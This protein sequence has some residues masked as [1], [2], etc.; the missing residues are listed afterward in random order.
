MRF[1]A[2]KSQELQVSLMLHKMRDLLVRQRAIPINALRAHLGDYG[3]VKAQGPAIVNAL[4]AMVQEVQVAI[5]AHARSAL[6]SIR[7][8]TVYWPSSAH[9]C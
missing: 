1:V 6:H 8:R 2:V 4:L 9:W 3:I 5:L 7:H